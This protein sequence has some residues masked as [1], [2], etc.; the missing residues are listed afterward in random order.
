MGNAIRL[1]EPN[2]VYAVV[3]T[4]VDRTF[5]FAPNHDPRSPLLARGC[6]VEALDPES[7]IVPV[8]SVI[9]PLL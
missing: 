4:T 7:P 3:Q 8:P 1:L 9:N 6:P 2:A 5:S